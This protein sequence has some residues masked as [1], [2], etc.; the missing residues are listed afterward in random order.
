VHLVCERD[1]T[2]PKIG[3]RQNAVLVNDQ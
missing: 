3:H 1:R 2:R